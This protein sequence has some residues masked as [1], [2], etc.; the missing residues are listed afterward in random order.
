MQGGACENE[1]R[2]PT[3]VLTSPKGGI[4]PLL[5]ASPIRDSLGEEKSSQGEEESSSSNSEL[6]QA[7][8]DP[9]NV[10]RVW[11]NW[12]EYMLIPERRRDALV[13]LGVG[14][15]ELGVDLFATPW[16]T[17]APLFITKEMDSFSF[18]WGSLMSDG[19]TILWANPP[20][21]ALDK[22]AEKLTFEKCRVALVTP[23]WEDHDWW[24]V[25]EKLPHQKIL[26]PTRTPLYYGGF[27]KKP[28]PPVKNWRTVVWL[29][30]TR[31]L[32][33]TSNPKEKKSH[34]GLEELK[35]EV[36]KLPAVQWTHGFQGGKPA[37]NNH[38]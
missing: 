6:I 19:D 38:I 2:A 15:V 31:G 9:S 5:E 8:D 32:K 17:A 21:A 35:A 3:L 1:S 14:H 25:L 33:R 26:L 34:R 18:D 16:A 22:V 12:G 11:G 4:Y 13:E 36:A 27:R 10:A 28:L 37:I 24:K 20:F 30:D 7:V 29:I 23:D